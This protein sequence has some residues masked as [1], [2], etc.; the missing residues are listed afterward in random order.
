[1]SVEKF[2]QRGSSYPSLTYLHACVSSIVVSN[3]SSLIVIAKTSVLGF[4]PEYFLDLR[5]LGAFG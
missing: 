2:I 3:C 5:L 4:V 1:M